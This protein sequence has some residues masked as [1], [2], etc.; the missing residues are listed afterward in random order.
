VKLETLAKRTS[1][2]VGADIENIVNEAVPSNLRGKKVL[3]LD[4]NGLMAG[5]KYRGEF[6][7]RMKK[8]VDD[9]LIENR[10]GRLLRWMAQK[11]LP[12]LKRWKKK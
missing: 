8:I 5:T 9:A 2:L 6:E 1:G 10:S 3:A 12:T 4:L 7:S 11:Q